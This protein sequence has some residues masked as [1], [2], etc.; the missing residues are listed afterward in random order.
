MDKN[1]STQRVMDNIIGAKTPN[2]EMLCGT[3]ECRLRCS[4]RLE[5]DERANIFSEFYKLNAEGQ[6]SQLFG[7]MQFSQP[8]TVILDAQRRR[9]IAVKYT[10]LMNTSVVQVC[11]KAFMSLHGISQSNVS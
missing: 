5:K 8:K 4:T 1:M 9:D 7:C 11:K 10:V 3:K 6:N 2:F